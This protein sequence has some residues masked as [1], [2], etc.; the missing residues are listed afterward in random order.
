M[1][2]LATFDGLLRSHQ[3]H[4]VYIFSMVIGM[5]ETELQFVLSYSFSL[6][7]FL[8]SPLWANSALL[9]RENVQNSEVNGIKW[10]MVWVRCFCCFSFYLAPSIGSFGC[11]QKEQNANLRRFAL[12]RIYY[13][14]SKISMWH[15]IYIFL[16]WRMKMF[17]LHTV[18]QRTTY[19]M[20]TFS[21]S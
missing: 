15:Y 14:D 6:S 4:L 7:P 9:W 2:T 5:S 18:K 11:E 1:V 17:H 13:W 20:T 10:C 3:V 19:V 21:R 8:L 12:L 16:I